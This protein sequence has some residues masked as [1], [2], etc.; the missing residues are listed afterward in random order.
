MK[1]HTIALAG[2]A[3]AAAFS[4]CSISYA[5]GPFAGLSG[6]WSGSGTI[7]MASGA[8]ERIICRATYNV[9]SGG[10]TLQQSLR[11]T[12]SSYNFLLSSNLSYEG[13]IIS[14]SWSEA[15][16]NAS[17]AIT[18]RASSGRIQALAEGPAFS[19]SLSV[20]TRGDRQ[21]VTISTQ[22][23]DITSVS[24]TLRKG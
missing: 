18:G 8:R 6:S 7:V 21:S 15:T 9:G 16:R 10:S 2:V 19:A 20:V 17:G 14:G 24:I 22:S 13:G 12:S 3:F 5:Q 4:P 11:C 23:G 1:A